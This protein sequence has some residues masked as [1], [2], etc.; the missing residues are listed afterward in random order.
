MLCD[1]DVHQTLIIQT[2]IIVTTWIIVTAQ[3]LHLIT[4]TTHDPHDRHDSQHKSGAILR[5]ILISIRRLRLGASLMK[6]NIRGHREKGTRWHYSC[7]EKV[8][9]QRI[10]YLGGTP[11]GRWQFLVVVLSNFRP[12]CQ[13]RLRDRWQV[14]GVMCW[15]WSRCICWR[16]C[17]TPRWS[18]RRRR[19]WGI[20]GAYT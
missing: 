18:H 11:V 3:D 4:V 19:S 1:H 5:S 13:Q 17:G 9:D 12:H 10:I 8:H 20:C 15:L 14:C 6:A 7:T 2:R 16:R